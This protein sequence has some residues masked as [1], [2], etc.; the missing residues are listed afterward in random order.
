MQTLGQLQALRL[1]DGLRLLEQIA[2]ERA[3]GR[4]E[5]QIA[6]RLRADHPADLVAAGMTLLAVRERA[7]TKFSRADAMWLTRAGF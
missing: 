5:L 1:P 7:A 4:S 3:A 2:G 6:S